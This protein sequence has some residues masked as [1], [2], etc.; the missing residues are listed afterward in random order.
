M[1]RLLVCSLL[2]L[3]GCAG[4]DDAPPPEVVRDPTEVG[5]FR[6]PIGTDHPVDMVQLQR[7][8]V[9]RPGREA[10]ELVLDLGR[11]ALEGRMAAGPYYAHEPGV[12]VDP[13]YRGTGTVRAGRARVVVPPVVIDEARLRE[14]RWADHVVLSLRFEFDRSGESDVAVSRRVHAW[15]RDGELQPVVSIVEGPMLARRTSDHPDWLDFALETD[16]PARATIEVE[17]VG[18]FTTADEGHRHEIRVERLRP[19]RTYRYRALAHA[20]GDSAAT[21]WIDFRTAPSPGTGQAT[22]VFGGDSR[23]GRGFGRHRELGVNHFVLGSI[24]RDARRH[25]PDFLL[26]AGDLVNGY[27][28]RVVDFVTELRSWKQAVEPFAFD[29]PVFAAI[30]NHDVPVRAYYKRKFGGLE[31]DRWPYATESASALFAQ[32]LVMP[33][34]APTPQEG[35]PPYD[36][37]IY[38]FTHGPLRVLVLNNNYWYTTHDRIPDVGGSPE[39]YF[40]PEQLDWLEAELDRANQ[41]PAVRY[42]V[43]CAQ[44]PVWPVAG[45][46]HDAM[47]HSGNNARRALRYRGDGTFAPLGPGIVEV[48][49]RLWEMASRQPKVAAFLTGDEHNYSRT[50]ITRET[51]V[52]LPGRDD[53]DGDGRLDAPFSPNPDFGPPL[54]SIVSGGAGAPFYRREDVPWDEGVRAFSTRFHY[55]VVRADANAISL[56]AHDLHG[57][58]IDRVDDLMG[59]RRAPE[60]AARR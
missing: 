13:R 38:A 41:D 57:A 11:S 22:L 28:Q 60:S 40:L 39:G 25:D 34:G 2:V 58:V 32:E 44:E 48:R 23:A 52:G 4:V 6:R 3:T 5:F 46:A 50:L 17:G 20:D 26:F 36:E 16:R 33:L 35:L 56:T 19:S 51:P 27:S 1:R 30:G 47:W 43:L 10:T 18:R 54:W 12:V 37:T 8:T 42:V 59:V 31:M 9:I 21:P 29:R 14:T 7:A 49:N 55:V 15:M 53:R 45:H 24:V